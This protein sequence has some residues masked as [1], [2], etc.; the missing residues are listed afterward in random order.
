MKFRPFIWKRRRRR[1]RCSGC[2][3][4][5]QSVT[6]ERMVPTRSID[7][8]S[9][10]QKKTAATMSHRPLLNKKMRYTTYLCHTEDLF[11]CSPE[12]DQHESNIHKL[13]SALKCA[14]N[15]A[16]SHTKLLNPQHLASLFPKN[17]SF[18]WHRARRFIGVW[19]ALTHFQIHFFLCCCFFFLFDQTENLFVNCHL[20][21]QIPGHIWWMAN[22]HT[23]KLRFFE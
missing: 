19:I 9:A 22:G 5:I 20:A 12:T 18:L 2:L 10:K 21:W 15:R 13:N 16:R 23:L 17:C 4:R 7:Q 6:H 1:R 3:N 14:L 11:Q 8:K